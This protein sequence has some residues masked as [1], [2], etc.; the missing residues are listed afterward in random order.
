LNSVNRDT[1][2][3]YAKDIN[4]RSL[5]W[6]HGYPS[7]I[8]NLASYLNEKDIRLPLRWVS[9]GAESLFRAIRK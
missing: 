4:K 1:V 7:N 9:I 3:D 6:L 8:S 2:E 5:D